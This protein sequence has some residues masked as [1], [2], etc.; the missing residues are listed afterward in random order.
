[1]IECGRKDGVSLDIRKLEKR[2]VN[3]RLSWSLLI[4]SLILLFGVPVIGIIGALLSVFLIY[5]GDKAK[6]QLK[7]IRQAD[8]SSTDTM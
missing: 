6:K 8:E 3:G 4:L 2:V 1:M 7:A 5:K